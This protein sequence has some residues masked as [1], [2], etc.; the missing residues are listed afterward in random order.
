MINSNFAKSSARSRE[1]PQNQRSLIL[2]VGLERVGHEDAASAVKSQLGT[3]RREWVEAA[4]PCA[5]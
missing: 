1:P 2:L 5:S 3:V 4:K